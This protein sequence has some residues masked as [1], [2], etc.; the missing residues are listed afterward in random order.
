M[1]ENAE[2]N[3]GSLGLLEL[4]EVLDIKAATPL[5]V[6][7]LS[8]RGRPILVNASRVRQLGGLCLQVLLSAAKTWRIDESS[9]AL[10]NPSTDFTEGLAR[11]GI[12]VAELAGQ[13]KT[14]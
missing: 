6:E 13:E 8:L 5:A 11:L 7:F 12:S 4:P 3:A 14:R 1:Q 9:F 2:T 10:V